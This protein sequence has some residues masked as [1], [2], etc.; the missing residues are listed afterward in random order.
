MSAE[1]TYYMKKNVHF[2][3][4]Q[5][6]PIN[7]AQFVHIVHFQEWSMDKNMVKKIWVGMSTT[8]IYLFQFKM[9]CHLQKRGLWMPVYQNLFW[10]GKNLTFHLIYVPLLW[11]KRCNKLVILKSTSPQWTIRCT[12]M[13]IARVLLAYNLIVFPFGS[14]C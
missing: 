12:S 8:D 1:T 10:T 9:Q 7:I 4:C 11:C 2:D 14:V 3:Q 13:L 5:C 6:W